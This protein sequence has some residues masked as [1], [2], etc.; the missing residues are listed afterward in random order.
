[1]LFPLSTVFD[2]LADLKLLDIGAS[3]IDGDPPYKVLHDTGCAELVGFEPDPDQYRALL[4]SDLPRSKFL[5]VALGAGGE[6]ELKICQSPGMTSLLEPDP[7]V[8]NRFHGFGEWGRVVRREPMM[9][10]RLD[11]VSE[12]QASDYMKIDVQGGELAVF[13]G[14]IRTLQG[15]SVVHTEVQFVPFY[16]DQ[17]LFAELDQFLRGNGFF[18]HRFLPIH[19]RVFKPMMI[20]SDP[21]AGLSQELWTDAVYVRRFTDFG[22]L[23]VPQLLKIATLLNDL[24][25][26][27]DLASLALQYAD[28]RE[29]TQRQAAYLQA[30]E[31]SLTA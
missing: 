29:G 5:P 8:L 15:L 6:A 28:E 11:D 27:I 31:A 16:R 7:Q 21:Y 14:G 30:L 12:A 13:E 18:F 2:D 4:E 23:P 1:M 17:P 9:T 26:S 24:Y 25:E 20:N 19:S 10:H 3:P 22:E